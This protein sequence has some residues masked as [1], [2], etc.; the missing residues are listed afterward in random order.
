MDKPETPTDSSMSQYKDLFVQTGKEYL[1]SLNDSLLKLE[2]NPT[3][4]TAIAEIFRSAH[5]LKGQSAAMG[6][7]KTGYLCH[8]VEDVFF[9]IKE[10]RMKTSPELADL[11]FT[12]FDGLSASV[13]H[14]EADGAE[15][16]LSP[17]AEAL[18]QLTGVQTQGAGKSD[19][20]AP[21]SP[22]P[23]PAPAPSSEPKTPP[24]PQPTAP[25]PAQPAA[26]APAQ[27]TP[28]PAATPPIP[29]PQ[30]IKTIPVKVEQ[31]DEM[32]NLL[33]ELIVHRLVLKRLVR[34]IG[35]PELASYQDQIQKI[36]AALQFQIMNVRAVPVKLVFDHFPRAVRDLARAENKHIELV[37]EGDD[38]ELDRTIVERLDEPL[39]HLIRNAASH[40]I[41]QSG[42]LWLRARR[43]KDYAVVEVADN[44]QGVD[45][46]AVAKKAHVPATTDLATLK[47]LLFSGISTS[48]T[49]TQVSGRGVGLEVVK[50]TIEE[51]GGRIDVAS[52][53]GHGT[54]F[55]IRLPLTLAVT[56]ALLVRVGSEHYAIP[57][58]AVDR[59]VKITAAQLQK[60]AGQ[61]AFVLEQTEVPLLYL[62]DAF[63]LPP[64]PS[65]PL[66]LLAVIITLGTD[67]IGLVV[68]EIV[69][70]SEIIIKPAP[71]LLQ[72]NP[73][74]AGATILGNGHSA[75][76][77]NP[78]GL[79]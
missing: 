74:F 69:E 45:W 15:V 2:K 35:N 57:A 39:T 70:A 18:K 32:M 44:G 23:S 63:H 72:G 37:I 64:L 47:K 7:E 28:A 61:A 43:E 22:A 78:Q 54:T 34:E 46:A 16:D 27:S 33:E 36:T 51:F 41:A 4:T 26:P 77:L 30:R 59:S 13:A 65:P 31:L 58:S 21:S 55:T 42:T 8:A 50:K 5:S 24:A 17:Q 29:T 67:R 19:R 3:D 56:K 62:R 10:G 1:K 66:D 48:E 6:Y 11:L 40:G 9:E 73:A 76:I 20:G 79:L 75:L 52:E 49:V 68:D 53:L 71:A 25:T 14:I 12:A 60:T 38:L